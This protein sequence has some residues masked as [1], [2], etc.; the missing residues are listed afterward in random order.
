MLI[1]IFIFSLICSII[2]WINI[3]I[4]EGCFILLKVLTLGEMPAYYTHINSYNSAFGDP[5]SSLFNCVSFKRILMQIAAARNT[6]RATL[7]FSPVKPSAHI[8]LYQVLVNRELSQGLLRRPWAYYRE[9]T[10]YS[11]K[12]WNY[13]I[14]EHLH[15][16]YWKIHLYQP[17]HSS[18]GPFHTSFGPSHTFFSHPQ[19]FNVDHKYQLNKCYKKI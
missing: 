1:Q 12:V 11:Y 5:A 2:L 17:F 4:Q 16:F 9:F 6:S 15:R 8:N 18:F 3:K 19:I 7:I 14:Y 10:V 13:E